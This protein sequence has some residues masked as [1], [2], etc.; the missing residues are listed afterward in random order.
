MS[1]LHDTYPPEPTHEPIHTVKITLTFNL[2]LSVGFD[3]AA[4][5]ERLVKSYSGA[6][7]AE[8]IETGFT[9]WCANI[10]CA[11]NKQLD[12]ALLQENLKLVVAVPPADQS[13][14]RAIENARRRARRQLIN[15]LLAEHRANVARIAPKAN[16]TLLPGVKVTERKHYAT[17]EERKEAQRARRR[18]LRAAKK[19]NDTSA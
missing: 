5:V 13:E 4:E 3:T 10:E 12:D 18:E 1:K 9:N 17:I 7:L 19:R 14:K 15:N 8:D 6:Q 16:L 11:E 2:S